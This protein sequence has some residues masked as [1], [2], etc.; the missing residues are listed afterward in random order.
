MIRASGSV[1]LAR[2]C[3]FAAHPVD[4]AYS[5]TRSS[6]LVVNRDSGNLLELDTSLEQVLSNVPIGS[7]PLAIA[8]DEKDSQVWVINSKGILAPGKGLSFPDSSGF[9]EQD[10]Y[11]SVSRLTLPLQLVF[12]LMTRQ[13]LDQMMGI[14]LVNPTAS[15]L[16]LVFTLLNPGGTKAPD[17][18]FPNPRT[19]DLA[20]SNQMTV[21]D[22]QILGGT[23][24]SDGW[25]HI[26]TDSN[27]IKGFSLVFDRDV[28][29]MDGT[30]ENNRSL[31]KAVFPALE[32]SSGGFSEFTLCNYSILSASVL[33]RLVGVDGKSLSETTIAIPSWGYLHRKLT[34]LFP[35]APLSQASY[36]T[37]ESSVPL[38]A[39]QSFGTDN[40]FA[41]LNALDQ[42]RTSNTLDFAHFAS[43]GAYST[44]LTL[45]NLAAETQQVVVSALDDAGNL[46]KTGN[47]TNPWTG[48]IPSQ[49][50][51]E[52]DLQN[53][54]GFGGSSIQQGSLHVS[55]NRGQ[56]IGYITFGTS[57]ALV[58]SIPQ[59]NPA[60]SMT[61]SHIAETLDGKFNYFTGF[62]AYNPNQ[63][64]VGIQVVAHRADGS[65]LGN[66]NGTLLPKG[67]FSRLLRELPGIAGSVLGQTGGYF[68]VNSTHPIFALSLFGKGDLSA[69]AVIPAQ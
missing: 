69:L 17:G 22:S 55:G 61:F 37:M 65:I 38:R 27:R 39:R 50:K 9:F 53:N 57:E 28:R 54:M 26:Q 13:G 16:R 68:E 1:S 41:V 15:P 49:I 6:F 19:W 29:Y 58:S 62:A 10:G 67:H 56:L 44:R 43:G 45:I 34:E 63:E 30:A 23:P 35:N 11:S 52:I 59:D 21:L 18:L 5:P 48:E 31:Q 2:A 40:R 3:A 32:K 4:L 7:S 25:V 46:M 60:T 33:F 51:V 14:A 8:L 64:P 42:A 36:L 12:P 24:P 47:V 20:S 66:W